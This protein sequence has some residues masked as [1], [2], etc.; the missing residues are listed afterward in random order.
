MLFVVKTGEELGL[1][2]KGVEV[3]I[4]AEDEG[5]LNLSIKLG[6][7]ASLGPILFQLQDELLELLFLL[8]LPTF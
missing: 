2:F 8:R 1:L 5:V 7:G 6:V 4:G 3:V